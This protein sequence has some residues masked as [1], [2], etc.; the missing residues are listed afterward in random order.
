MAAFLSIAAVACGG[1]ASTGNTPQEEAAKSTLVMAFVPSQQAQTVLVS[2]KPIADYVAKEVGVP[3]TAQ[4]PTSYAAV[5]EAMTSGN[6]DIA[7]VG[8]LDYVIAHEKNGAEP[9]TKSVRKGVPGYNAFIIAR[10]GSGIKSVKDLKGKS[11]AF[12]D[13]VSAS[14][15]LY[16]KYYM[17]QNG[18]DP[19]KDL[20]KAVNISNQT[21]IATSVCNGVV[22][23]GAIYDDA[24]TNTGA[25]TACPGIMDKTQI[26]F[27]TPNLI[28]GDP[29]MVRH[30]MNAG[31]KKKV[32]DAMIKLGT[33]P[34]MA[35]YLKA[36]FTIE[37]TVPA[38]DAD[39]NEIRSIVKAV[40]PTLLTATPAPASPAATPSASPSK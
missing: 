18:I 14:S 37:K 1:A 38:A 24:R 39:Y 35:Q 33:D 28:P 6:V 2:A 29:Q 40:N 3:I 12:G 5:T 30:Q 27:T 13:P 11:F 32:V 20:A 22:D 36:L 8:P 4:V 25:D 16:P 9:V 7:W 10:K 26:I 17:K 21:A 15:N 19:E 23:A 31:Q 34:A